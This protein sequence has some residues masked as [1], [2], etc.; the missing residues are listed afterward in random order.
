MDTTLNWPHF[1][2]YIVNFEHNQHLTALKM[3]LLLGTHGNPS[4]WKV[5]LPSWNIP[6][7]LCV[8][9]AIVIKTVNRRIHVLNEKLHVL[10]SKNDIFLA[11]LCEQ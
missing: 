8:L 7:L 10:Y 6:D 11:E 5:F 1:G 2:G 9:Q 4:S 3:G